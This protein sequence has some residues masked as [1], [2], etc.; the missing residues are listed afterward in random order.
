MQQLPKLSLRISRRRWMYS[1]AHDVQA[2]LVEKLSGQKFD[3]F[4]GVSE[5]SVL[6]A[7]PIIFRL[8]DA[9]SRGNREY[10]SRTASWRG[11]RGPLAQNYGDVV[12]GGFS[13]STTAADYADSPRCCERR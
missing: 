13:I 4:V 2:A 7:C 12:L 5:S 6:S 11:T 9:Q 10:I 3:D 1:V 8:A